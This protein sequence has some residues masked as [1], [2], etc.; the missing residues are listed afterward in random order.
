M[1]NLDLQIESL[2]SKNLARA[3]LSFPF[4]PRLIL[5]LDTSTPY[6]DGSSRLKLVDDFAAR[7]H[8]LRMWAVTTTFTGDRHG[9]TGGRA[10]Y[11]V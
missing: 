7:E 5:Q 3:V 9:Y 8:S 11:I 2:V 4:T 10:K 1:Y 6:V